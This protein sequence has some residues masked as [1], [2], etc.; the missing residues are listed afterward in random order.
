MIHVFGSPSTQVSV[1][2]TMTSRFPG[3]HGANTTIY[4][5]RSDLLPVSETFIKAQAGSLTRFR[6][7]FVGLNCV[8][9]GLTVDANAITL[10]RGQSMVA[11]YRRRLYRSTGIAPFFHR[12]IA[13]VGGSLVHAHFAP[14]G[15]VIGPLCRKLKLPLIVTLHGYDV[16]ATC[17][18]KN[19]Y[20]RLWDQAALF[21]CISEF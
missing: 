10:T 7:Q 3:A 20:S 6:R 11:R 18:F 5:Y 21:I 4:V 12:K 15:A 17:D 9:Y 14:D 19:R 8:D 16:T 2:E 1:Q 13:A